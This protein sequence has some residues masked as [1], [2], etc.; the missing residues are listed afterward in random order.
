M[1]LRILLFLLVTFLTLNTSARAEVYQYFNDEGT[2][3]VTDNPYNIKKP[4]ARP[5]PRQESRHVH[6]Q[7]Q[8]PV[9]QPKQQVFS[10]NYI[11]DV[12]Y[13]YYPVS[14]RNFMEVMESTRANGPFDYSD[15]RRYA[16]QTRWTVGWSYKFGSTYNREGGYLRAAVNIYDFDF[17]TDISVLMP[18]LAPES[19]LT[20]SEVAL[21]GS[22]MNGLLEHENDHVKIT[23][24]PGYR[25]EALRMISDIKEVL[26]PFDPSYDVNSLI[27]SAVEAE[28]AKVGHSLIK[29]IKSRNE[30]YDRVTEHG[31]KHEMRAAFFGGR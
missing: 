3:I 9:V 14:G 25:A 6:R 7:D 16:G 13:E 2:L 22:F 23:T 12:T 4:K 29:N 8:A 21:W 31:I 1:S 18:A 19:T 20:D 28:T 27:R 15:N 11:D 10:P 17:R 26:V 24:D 5:A 30:E